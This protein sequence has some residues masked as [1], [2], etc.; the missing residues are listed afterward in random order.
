VYKQVVSLSTPTRSSSL[1][2]CLVPLCQ[3]PRPYC[4]AH[5]IVSTSSVPS[6]IC[7]LLAAADLSFCRIPIPPWVRLR[8]QRRPQ[9]RPRRP[10]RPRGPQGRPMPKQLAASLSG[11]A[12]CLPRPSSPPTTTT[13]PTMTPAHILRLVDTRPVRIRVHVHVPLARRPSI[14]SPRCFARPTL[15]P[16]TPTTYTLAPIALR[17]CSV[18]ALRSTTLV[19]AIPPSRALPKSLARTRPTILAM[20]I[21]MLSSTLTTLSSTSI[22]LLRIL[23]HAPLQRLPASVF[24]PLSPDVCPPFALTDP[25]EVLLLRDSPLLNHPNHDRH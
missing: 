23:N 4:S 13:R 12:R 21:H 6:S 3:Q 10:R 9:R 8:P 5:R 16:T 2:L 24:Q 14:G 18:L 11:A 15:L 7:E 25:H 17:A 22:L 20:A 19:L 1:T